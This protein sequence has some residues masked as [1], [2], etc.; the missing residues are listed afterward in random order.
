MYLKIQKKKIP[1][2]NCS[3]FRE[4]FK[5]LKMVIDP[6]D[7]GIVL[8]KKKI[9]NTYFFCQK[10]DVIVTNKEYQIIKM[11][12]NFKSE[13]IRF[14]FKGYYLFFFPLHTCSSFQV[15]DILPIKK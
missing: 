6:I 2:Q 12:Q 1:I 4:K 15:G 3:T 7:Y 11:Y 9:I 13:K 14:N 8:E 5:S 10:V